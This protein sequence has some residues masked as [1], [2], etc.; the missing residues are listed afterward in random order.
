LWLDEPVQGSLGHD[1]DLTSKELAEP[2]GETD[3]VEPR[4]RRIYE[5]VEVA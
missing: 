2:Q 4:S 1:V 3:R 5:D